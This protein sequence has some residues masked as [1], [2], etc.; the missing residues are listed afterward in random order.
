MSLH[1]RI[2]GD[3]DRVVVLS[4]SIGSTTD[5]WEAQLAALTSHHRVVRIDH[6]GHGGSPLLDTR[7]IGELADEVVAV[8]DE[9]DI[10]HFSFCGLSLG[11][12]VA[13]RLALDRRTARPGSPTAAPIPP[14]GARSISGT[15]R[16]TA[17][18]A[19]WCARC[20]R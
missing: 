17:A 3:A 2:D 7:T 14:T 20:R 18:R 11:G 19:A 16:R 5:V 13:M 4:G 9:L 10:E 1:Y 12:T 15:T 8:L 6:P